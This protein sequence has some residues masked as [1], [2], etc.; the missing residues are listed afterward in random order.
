M[1][2]GIGWPVSS[3]PAQRFSRDIDDVP[4]PEHL[5]LYNFMRPWEEVPGRFKM[6]P[7]E[8]HNYAENV[9]VKDGVIHLAHR[10]DNKSIGDYDLPNAIVSDQG[11]CPTITAMGNSRFIASEYIKS[12]GSRGMRVRRLMPEECLEIMG[13][14]GKDGI[15]QEYIDGMRSGEI[16]DGVGYKFAGNSVPTLLATRVTTAVKIMYDQNWMRNHVNETVNSCMT[17]FLSQEGGGDENKNRGTTMKQHMIKRLAD[18]SAQIRDL[19]EGENSSRERYQE[20]GKLERVEE[21][22][23]KVFTEQGSAIRKMETL[24]SQRKAIRRALEKI[25]EYQ[26]SQERQETTAGGNTDKEYTTRH[27][28]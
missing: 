18:I 8:L 20:K 16:S 4:I 14:S 24:T 21:L 10:V 25:E 9:F 22:T 26:N 1:R 27:R 2:I 13:F 3:H 23:R 6:K 11:V 19:E 15:D 17:G 28:C 7:W 12:D 5:K